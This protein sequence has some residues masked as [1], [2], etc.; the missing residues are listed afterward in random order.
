MY[1][2]H[3]LLRRL[4]S[5]VIYLEEGSSLRG[6]PK[7]Q[8]LDLGKRRWVK[9]L[10]KKV[11]VFELAVEAKTSAL[12]A[13]KLS[14]RENEIAEAIGAKDQRYT[15]IFGPEEETASDVGVRRVVRLAALNGIFRYRGGIVERLRQ[16]RKSASGQR[17]ALR[18]QIPSGADVERR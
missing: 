16:K 1:P 18:R 3:S 2:V 9:K 11:D 4:A 17:R 7:I 12:A 6:D 10:G 8:Q 5:T 13:Q 14:I 15:L